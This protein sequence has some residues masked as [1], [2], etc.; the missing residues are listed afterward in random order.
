[1]QFSGEGMPISK[2][3][4]ENG[5]LIIKFDIIFPKH[6]SLNKRQKLKEILSSES[7]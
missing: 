3:P 6:L 2:S 1:M 5:D 4:G 7:N